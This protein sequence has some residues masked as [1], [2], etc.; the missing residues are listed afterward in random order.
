M[1][2]SEFFDSYS[3]QARLQP[4][5]LVLFPLFIG[6]ATWVPAL[7]ELATGLVSLGVACG[8]VVYLAHVSRALGRKVELALFTC[9]GGKPT[10]LWLSHSDCNLDVQTKARYHAFL[11]E[12]IYGWAPPSPEDELRNA[13]AAAVSYESAVRWLREKTRNRKKYYLVFRENISYG[14]RRNLYGLKRLG[15]FLALLCVAGN[16][17]AIYHDVSKVTATIKPEGVASL[18]LSL[19]LVGGWCTVVRISWVRDAADGYAR[20]LLASCDQIRSEDAN[21]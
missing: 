21:R 2:L 11:A 8:A 15:I 6:V 20:A 16:S 18:A 14:F 1:E 4:A 17:C 9:W 7:Y 3:R 13:Q 5:L 12:H 10:T 19:V